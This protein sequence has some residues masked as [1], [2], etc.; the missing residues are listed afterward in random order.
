MALDVVFGEWLIDAMENPLIQYAFLEKFSCLG[1]DCPDT[2]CHGW[3][4]PTDRRQR[5]L[6]AEKAPELLAA[7]D[8]EQNIM[9]R[10]PVTDYCVKLEG[11]LC[12]VHKQ[13]GD[14]FL[15]DA[16]YFYPRTTRDL[17]GTAL[18]G[19]SL[20][21]PESLRLVLEEPNPFALQETTVPRLPGFMPKPLAEGVSWEAAQATMA[22]FMALAQDETQSPEAIMTQ[23]V[24]ISL[25]LSH[26]P[27][28]EWLTHLPTLIEATEPHTPTTPTPSDPFALLYAL[29][30][31][32]MRGPNTRRPRLE[33]TIR[34]I[35]AGLD[36]NLNWEARDMSYG[37]HAGQAYQYLQAR[38]NMGAKDALA[39][40]L[41]R[42]I[43]GQF[44]AGAWPF[45]GFAGTTLA[46]RATVLAVRFATVRLA[47]MCRIELDG[48][49]PSQDVVIAT[50]QGIS[51]FMDHL[52][53]AE[54][55]RLIYRDA[56]WLEN[57]ARLVG[58]VS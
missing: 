3:Q 19:A 41:R 44:A 33:E 37:S 7:T 34:A 17:G 36:C 39:P 32:I 20:S 26:M 28:T 29:G 45:A 27:Q 35:E 21:C 55:S 58:L 22:D 16:C 53:D 9:R 18:M 24:R 4:M 54:L 5:D 47:L 30:V 50:I 31:L 56:G 43:Q 2:C 1:A 49:P 10:D 38:W 52:A 13:Y 11:G 8:P 6:Y 12:G 25:H 14:N 57:E 15:G 48:T 40:T 42:W 46:E 51:R 23:V